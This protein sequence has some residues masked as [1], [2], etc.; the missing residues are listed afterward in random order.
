MVDRYNYKKILTIGFLSLF[1]ILAINELAVNYHIYFIYKWFD[2][3]MH[4]LGGFAV[5]IFSIGILR[6]FLSQEQYDRRPV[7][8]YYV[9]M[10]LAIGLVWE[11]VEVFYKVSVI[12]GGIFWF[13]TIKDLLMDV[14]GGILSYIC[15]HHRLKK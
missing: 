9:G 10:V 2:T 5:G 14:F 6:M 4:F 1:L 13:D 3:P 7:F 11:L 8:L 12:F 15:F